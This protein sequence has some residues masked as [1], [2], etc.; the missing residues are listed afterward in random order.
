ME[1][2]LDKLYNEIRED[3]IALI[4]EKNIDLEELLNKLEVTKDEFISYFTKRSDNF[5]F[6][7]QTFSLLEHWEG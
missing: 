3:S 6:Y 5:I 7:L 2:E 1:K 4:K